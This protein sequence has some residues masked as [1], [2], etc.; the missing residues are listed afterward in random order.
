[1][2]APLRPYPEARID[3]DD[4]RAPFFVQEIPVGTQFPRRH[5]LAIVRDH[6]YRDAAHGN[7]DIFALRVDVLMLAQPPFRLV[8]DFGQN[9]RGGDG[10]Q[11]FSLMQ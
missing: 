6:I 4:F 10:L 3:D 2:R 11:C 7:E 5:Q 8:F 1:V 9:E